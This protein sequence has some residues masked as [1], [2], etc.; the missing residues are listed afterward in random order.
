M[1]SPNEEPRPFLILQSGNKR[2][3]QEKDDVSVHRYIQGNNVSG[4]CDR[5]YKTK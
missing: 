4:S 1:R 5:M 2:L 3:T